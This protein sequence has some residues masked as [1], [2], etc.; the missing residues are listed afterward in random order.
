[1]VAVTA[2]FGLLV[3]AAATDLL[4]GCLTVIASSLDMMSLLFKTIELTPLFESR[5]DQPIHIS[6]C[7]P[8]A[9]LFLLL[10]KYD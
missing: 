5:H 10:P 3:S 1:M 9:G 8:K 4:A 2:F 7:L 6:L